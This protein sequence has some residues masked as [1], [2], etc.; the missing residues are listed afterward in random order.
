MVSTRYSELFSSPPQ[1][2][3]NRESIAHLCAQSLE[4]FTKQAGIQS[5]IT[6]LVVVFLLSKAGLSYIQI[7]VSEDL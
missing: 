4:V 7:L 3:P 5:V 2:K 6:D 1:K